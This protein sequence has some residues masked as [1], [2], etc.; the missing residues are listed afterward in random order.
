MPILPNLF[1][2]KNFLEPDVCRELR[3]EAEK[4]VALPAQVTKATSRVDVNMRQ[5]SR[6]SFST[7]TE[8]RINNLFH[9]LQPQLQDFFDVKLSG[10]EKFQ[11][12]LYCAGDFY[13]RHA[14]RNDKPESPN[15]IKARRI[16]IVLFLGN[17]DQTNSPD[18]YTGGTLV[19]WAD[20]PETPL[21]VEGEV[22]KLIA[23]PS[24][25]VH[26]VEPITSGKRYSIVNWFYE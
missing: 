20:S 7:A 3:V 4:C 15:Y 2:A 11:F 13:K 25:L 19:V 9:Q 17:E 12:L 6:L 14:D 23:F 18:S 10:F 26:E 24:D 1:I 21:R 8:E 16:S 22:G 5:T